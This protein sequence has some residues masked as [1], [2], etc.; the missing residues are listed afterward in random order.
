MEIV[1]WLVGEVVIQIYVC[2]GFHAICI[3]NFSYFQ[4][5]SKLVNMLL[6]ACPC[7]CKNSKTAEGIFTTFYIGAFLNNVPVNPKFGV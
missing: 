2:N 3:P 4:F 6:L 5:R 1:S 7:D